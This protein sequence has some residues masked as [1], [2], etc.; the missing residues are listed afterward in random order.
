MSPLVGLVVGRATHPRFVAAPSLGR[1][2]L[3][4]LVSLYLGATLFGLTLGVRDVIVGSGGGYAEVLW[5]R[6]LSIWY[7]TSLFV[8]AL[9]P[10]AYLTHVM[11]ALDVPWWRRPR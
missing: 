9:A 7:G 2:V 11:L 8:I 10:L 5:S 3:A 6:V 4:A 1:R